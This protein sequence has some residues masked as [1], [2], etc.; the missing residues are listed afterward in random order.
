[1]RIIETIQCYGIS[2]VSGERGGG[3]GAGEPDVIMSVVDE[4]GSSGPEDAAA[5]SIS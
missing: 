5:R 4:E 3:E 2:R 1:M